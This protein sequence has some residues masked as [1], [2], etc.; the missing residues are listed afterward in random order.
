LPNAAQG[1]DAQLFIQIFRAK[2]KAVPKVI[3]DRLSAYSSFALALRSLSANL[4]YINNPITRTLKTA[5]SVYFL[6]LRT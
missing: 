2:R 1:I 5:F 6:K 3:V 4:E